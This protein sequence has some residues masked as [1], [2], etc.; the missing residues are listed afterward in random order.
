MKTHNFSKSVPMPDYVNERDVFGLVKSK[1]TSIVKR[2][3]NKHLNA[4]DLKVVYAGLGLR[5]LATFIDLIIIT[6][7]ML[8]PEILFFS[9]NFSNIDFNSFRF[10]MVAAIWIFYHTG[11]DS[12]ALQGTIGKRLL[13]LKMVDLNGKKISIVRAFF[14]CLTV[15]ISIAPMGLGIWYISTDPKKRAWHD[16]IAGSYVI[17]S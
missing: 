6:C 13:K 14:R 12:S 2:L 15:F 11:F 1:R 7:L 4:P 3:K 17:K 8:I 5:T 10:F 16:L 9:F